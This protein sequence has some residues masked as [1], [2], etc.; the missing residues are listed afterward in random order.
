M[1][2]PSDIGA[3][4]LEL[5]QTV[6]SVLLTRRAATYDFE[7]LKD[8]QA[9]RLQ[10]YGLKS[11]LRRNKDHPLSVEAEKLSTRL[12]L[13]TLTILHIDAEPLKGVIRG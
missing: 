8:A 3:Y 2:T 10:V 9:L 12:S 1:P 13:K 11:A 6:E 7:R 5:Y 4:P